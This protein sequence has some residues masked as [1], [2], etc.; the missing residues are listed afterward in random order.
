MRQTKTTQYRREDSSF[1]VHPLI[2]FH[3]RHIAHLHLLHTCLYQYF[4]QT[5]GFRLRK[6]YTVVLE[7]SSFQLTRSGDSMP[8]RKHRVIHLVVGKNV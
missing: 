5:K 1:G 8:H 2:H 3:L 7:T 6:P 4:G